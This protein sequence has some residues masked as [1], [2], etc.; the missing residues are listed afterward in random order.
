MDNY[1]EQ[2]R[3]DSKDWEEMTEEELEKEIYS[4]YEKAESEYSK[5]LDLK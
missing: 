4:C 5:A 2:V 3:E 1:K